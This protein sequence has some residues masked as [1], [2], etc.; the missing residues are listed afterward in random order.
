MKP[1]NLWCGV[2]WIFKKQIVLVL[3]IFQNQKTTSSNPLKKIRIV[4]LAS[5]TISKI[6]E[7]LWF[8]KRTNKELMVLWMVIWFFQSFEKCGYILKPSLWFFR[9]K[10]MNLKNHHENHQRYVSML[11]SFNFWLVQVPVHGQVIRK[12]RP[13]IQKFEKSNFRI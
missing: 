9:T 6:L 4:V 5:P 13:P 8:Y 2:I 12:P 1:R 7:N 3:L 11:A 10:V